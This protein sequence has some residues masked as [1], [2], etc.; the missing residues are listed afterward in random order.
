MSITINI[1]Y[2]GK[3]GSARI[4]AEEMIK[5]GTVEKIRSESGNLRYEYFHLNPQNSK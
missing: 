1:Y 4:F 3:N 2:T 5:S